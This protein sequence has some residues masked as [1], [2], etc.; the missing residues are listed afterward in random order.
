MAT[1]C[2]NSVR[3][4]AARLTKVDTCGRPVTGS[5]SVVTTDGYISI[6]YSPQIS[7]GDEIE[8]KNACGQLCI[9]DKARD[10]VKWVDVEIVF[11]GVNPDAAHLITGFPL[12]EDYAGDNI[13]F[14]IDG[15]S[16]PA[17]SGYALE[18]WTEIPDAGACVPGSAGSWGYFLAPW[19]V[20][21]MVTDFTLE[22]GAA[23]FTYT[24]RTKAGSLWDVG[25]H[26]DVMAQD[27]GGTPGPLI[28]P[29][30]T[31]AHVRLQKVTLAPPAVSCAATALS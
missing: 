18:A 1:Q 11:C 14:D 16:S 7:E 2:W 10:Q 15:A 6:A 23:N 28:T 24:G 21:G 27:V 26:D 9:S 29:F 13:G 12:A 3:S 4:C 17:A 22:N 25:P 5:D 19:I 8:Q 20:S 30:S 31:T